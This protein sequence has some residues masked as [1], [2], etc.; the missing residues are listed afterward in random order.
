M[1]HIQEQ[2]EVHDND[3]WCCTNCLISHPPHYNFCHH[4]GAKKICDQILPSSLL[5]SYIYI[6]LYIRLYIRTC[7]S[8]SVLYI[9]IIISTTRYS[10]VNNWIF[11]NLGEE[12]FE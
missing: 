6:R 10:K 5:L 7:I 3:Y 4:C 11:K 9:Y 1:S 8:S 2:E 12:M